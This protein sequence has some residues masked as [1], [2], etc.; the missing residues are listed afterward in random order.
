L[1][2]KSILEIDESR[3]LA[4]DTLTEGVRSAVLISLERSVSNPNP[5]VTVGRKYNSVTVLDF[6]Y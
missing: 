1:S 4:M 5:H 3:V 6:E 2:R